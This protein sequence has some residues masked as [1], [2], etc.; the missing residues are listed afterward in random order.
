MQQS[1][2]KEQSQNPSTIA[3]SCYLNRAPRP[4]LAITD[5]LS[6]RHLMADKLISHTARQGNDGGGINGT[7]LLLLHSLPAYHDGPSSQSFP[8]QLRITALQYS[9]GTVLHVLNLCFKSSGQM[10]IE[11]MKHGR[12]GAT[13][14]GLG[15]HQVTRG[16]RQ[17]RMAQ[18]F[19]ASGFWSQQ[20]KVQPP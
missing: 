1:N 16:R 7:L 14:E 9:Q 8:Q 12:A 13:R 3:W 4:L 5:L 10:Q 11:C 6:C 19:P 18:R 20:V 2:A 15:E 17:R